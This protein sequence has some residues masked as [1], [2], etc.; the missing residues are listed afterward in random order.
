MSLCSY[1]K[2]FALTVVQK[3]PSGITRGFSRVCSLDKYSLSLYTKAVAGSRTVGHFWG[4]SDYLF[5]ARK[6][7]CVVLLLRNGQVLLF[8][9]SGVFNFFF[10]QSCSD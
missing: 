2:E 10:I 4:P 7:L 6:H 8:I 3:D 5:R 9:L 1:L